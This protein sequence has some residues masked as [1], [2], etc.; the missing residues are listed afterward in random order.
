MSYHG[1]TY[2]LYQGTACL[3]EEEISLEN[4]DQYGNFN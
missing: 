1:V 4:E 3:E 2:I